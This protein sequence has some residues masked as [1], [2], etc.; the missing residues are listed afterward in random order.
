MKHGPF[1]F[2][3]VLLSFASS[4][5]VLVFTPYIQLQFLQPVRDEQTGT[6][7][8]LP[9]GGEA[10]EGELVYAANGCLYCHSQQVHGRIRR[11]L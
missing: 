9:L 8:P 11:G 6:E 3:G 5:L 7:Y 2:L 4:W 10:V 1:I